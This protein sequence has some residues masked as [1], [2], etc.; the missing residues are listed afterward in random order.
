MDQRFEEHKVFPV[1]KNEFMDPMAGPC[2]RNRDNTNK[3]QQF[4]EALD[5]HMKTYARTGSKIAPTAADELKDAGEGHI[6]HNTIPPDDEIE[7]EDEIIEE[8]ARK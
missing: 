4:Q 1:N 8:Y 2:A 5:T 3:K 7:E 6:Q